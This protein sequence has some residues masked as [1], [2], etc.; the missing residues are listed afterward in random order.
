MPGAPD[1]LYVRARRALL[2][3]LESLSAHRDAVILAGA[4]AIYLHTGEGDLGVAPYTTDGDLAL[5]PSALVDDP[6]LEDSMRTG[7]FVLSVNPDLIGTWVSPD[8]IQ[9]DLLV[10]DA[11]GGSGRRAAR[12]GIHGNQGARKGRGREAVLVDKQMMVVGALDKSDLRRIDVWV[13]GPA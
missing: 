9:I 2:D 5:D 13:A 11:V 8:G 3:A 12:L 1:P 7:G 10:P 6:K 4:Q